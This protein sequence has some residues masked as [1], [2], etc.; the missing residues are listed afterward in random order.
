MRKQK[1]PPRPKLS[2]DD[3]K[4]LGYTIHGKEG[5][6]VFRPIGPT[7]KYQYEMALNTLIDRLCREGPLTPRQYHDFYQ[8]HKLKA[9]YIEAVELFGP[10]IFCRY[11]LAFL[12][13]KRKRRVKLGRTDEGTPPWRTMYN[14][15]PN[16]EDERIESPKLYCDRERCKNAARQQARRDRRRRGVRT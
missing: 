5:S 7:L 9:L 3:W 2:E 11:C 15:S 10:P 14:R 13:D 1:S 12:A 8:E 4:R 6:R 16:P